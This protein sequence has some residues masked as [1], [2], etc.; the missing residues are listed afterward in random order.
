L[1]TPNDFPISRGYSGGIPKLHHARATDHSQIL[2]LGQI[3]QEIVQHPI[4]EIDVVLVFAQV[5]EGQ[6]RDA[7]LRARTS[8]RRLRSRIAKEKE[9]HDR[10]REQSD[11]RR[12]NAMNDVPVSGSLDRSLG[13]LNDPGRSKLKGPR[14]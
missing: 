14:K 1:A 5:F 2:N 13:R 9:N 7:F 12:V 10:E 8:R 4:R 11:D 6:N 3:G